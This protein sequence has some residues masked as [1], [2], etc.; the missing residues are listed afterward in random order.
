MTSDEW[1]QATLSAWSVGN[2]IRGVSTRMFLSTLTCRPTLPASLAAM[3]F[4]TTEYIDARNFLPHIGT[5]K[6][7][8]LVLACRMELEP[9]LVTEATP[10]REGVKLDGV[11]VLDAVGETIADA[12]VD[13]RVSQLQ[14]V[15]CY[16]AKFE[17]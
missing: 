8:L 3:A 11:I 4:Y 12:S 1:K 14:V 5:E 6:L 9:E 17:S 15:A 7:E 13:A 16:L 2:C 10:V